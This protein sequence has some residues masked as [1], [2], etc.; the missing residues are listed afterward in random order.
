MMSAK[1]LNSDIH[2][3]LFIYKEKYTNLITEEHLPVTAF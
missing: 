3:Q 2:P 1:G